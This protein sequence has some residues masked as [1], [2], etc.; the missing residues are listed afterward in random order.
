MTVNKA[1]VLRIIE[2]LNEKAMTQYKLEQNSGILH[3][4]MSC[5][6][7]ERNKTVTLTT[8]ILIAKGF[9]ITFREFLNSPLF[10]EENLDVE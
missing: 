6:L 2:L 3:G 1:V 8:I 4:T 9:E 5:I 7:S 10:D